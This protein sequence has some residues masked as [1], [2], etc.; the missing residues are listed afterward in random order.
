MAVQPLIE[1]LLRPYA[2]THHFEL[3]LEPGL[4]L[5]SDRLMLTTL[6]E[7]LIS[8]ACKYSL[9]QRVSLSVRRDPS[10]QG[11]GVARIVVANRVAADTDPDAERLFERYYRHPAMS[12]RPGTGMGLHIAQSAATKIG[13]TLRY[14]VTDNVVTFEVSMQC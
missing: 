11:A 10:A 9:D 5:R 1:D 14:S 12:D 13:A 6:V 7:N 2:S 3:D 4:M 8:N